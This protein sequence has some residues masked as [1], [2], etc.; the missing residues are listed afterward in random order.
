MDLVLEKL[1]RDGQRDE[2]K[3]GDAKGGVSIFFRNG[4]IQLDP[5]SIFIDPDAD[6]GPAQKRNENSADQSAEVAPIINVGSK[7]Q[8]QVDHNNIQN[9]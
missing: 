3:C 9:V 1:S 4:I 2:E 5:G 7:T 8:E 6:H